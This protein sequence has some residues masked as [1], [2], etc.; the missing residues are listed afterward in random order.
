M[1][2]LYSLLLVLLLPLQLLRLL[3]RS[4][5]APA[6]RRRIGERLGWFTPPPH[7]R[8]LIWVHAVSLGE[9]LAA[10]PLLERILEQLPQY[11]LAV[12]TT[13]PTASAQLQRLFGTRVFHVYAPWDTPGA[14]RRSLSRLQPRLLL[15]M[16]TE[17]WPNLLLQCAR[18]GCPVLLANARLSARSAAR[19]RRVP[20]FTRRTLEFLD[21]IAAQ[22]EEDARRLRDL[23]AP[24]ERLQVLGNLKHD[25]QIGEALRAQAAQLRRAWHLGERPVLIAASTH[26]G[27]EELA[28]QAFARLRAAQPA[29]LLLLVPRHPERAGALAARCRDAGW[30]LC[31][32]SSGDAVDPAVDLLLVDTVGELLLFYG[33]ADI[34]VVGGSFAGHG[35]HNPLEPAAWG[36]PVLCGPSM[37]NFAQAAARLQAAG[38]LTTVSDGAQLAEQVLSLAA[39]EQARRDRGSAGRA[40]V[41]AGRGVL[42]ALFVQVLA[43]LPEGRTAAAERASFDLTRQRAGR[44]RP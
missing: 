36:L 34:A 39:D 22:T 5:R 6:Y 14:V 9:T 3:W 15:I 10:R 12:T 21:G 28:L 20:G 18:R 25:L 23:G 40:I 41:A 19:Y 8:P 29:A 42:E 16:E 37:F 38:A 26:P 33:L 1:R 13:T 11:R 31:R 35:G 2:H 30:N 24:T 17:L 7:D 43:L 4:R 27:E 32:R 44:R